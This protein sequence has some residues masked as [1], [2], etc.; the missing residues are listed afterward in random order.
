MAA[1][2]YLK[3][4]PEQTVPGVVLYHPDPRMDARIRQ[5]AILLEGGYDLDT[6]CQTVKR[7]RTQVKTYFRQIRIARLMYIHAFPEEFDSGLDSLR[8]AIQD[9]RD[10]DRFL[11]REFF[12]AD[13]SNNASN[14]VGILKLI[15][16]NMQGLEELT[17]LTVQ[18]I[19]H[20]GTVGVKDEMRT[21]L[22]QAPASLRERYLDALSA[23]VHAA[24]QRPAPAE[25]ESG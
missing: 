9:R 10:F 23:L 12:H 20:S 5:V 6:I 7:G 17:G 22:D 3:E 1:H 25:S 2:N 13:R 8:L 11:R 21:L 19:Q 14:K 16:A 4:P 24:E 15:M 18:R